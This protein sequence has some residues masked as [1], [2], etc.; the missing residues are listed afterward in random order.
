MSE[1]TSE[2]RNGWR[3]WSEENE[4]SFCWILCENIMIS[5]KCPTNNLRGGARE[6]PRETK[7]I[8]RNF[9]NRWLI[10][11]LKVENISFTYICFRKRSQG[12]MEM[13]YQVLEGRK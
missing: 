3:S 2:S 11:N 6:E 7:S 1:F 12:F 13:F 10:G 8:F 5:L 4:Y 9:L